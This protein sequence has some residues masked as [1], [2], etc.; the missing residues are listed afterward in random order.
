MTLRTPAEFEQAGKL[1][2]APQDRKKVQ[3][4]LRDSVGKLNDSGLAQATISTRLSA[5]YDAIFSGALA[6]TNAQGYRVDSSEGHHKIVI[7]ILASSLGY[8]EFQHQELQIVR[9]GRNQRYD[10]KPPSE[11][12]VK[13]ARVWAERVLN[14]VG[15]WFQDQHPELLKN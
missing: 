2:K 1:R 13:E 11:S 15:Q 7:E 4:W 9:E 14:D 8:S 3:V 10:G 5:A 6:L 12:Q